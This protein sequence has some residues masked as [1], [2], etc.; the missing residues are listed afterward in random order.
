MRV[1]YPALLTIALGSQSNLKIEAVGNALNQLSINA[2][3]VACKVASSVAEQPFEQ[4]TIE[5]AKNRAREAATLLRDADLA[6]AIENGI[7]LRDGYWQDIGIVVAWSKYAGGD[8]DD[9]FTL[10]ESAP[11]VFPASIVEEVK[12]LGVDEWT[13][14]K[15]MARRQIVSKH[16]DPHMSLTGI[17]RR[18]YLENAIVTLMLELR[19]R[20]LV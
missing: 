1:N 13:C 11:V 20:S 18:I 16:D 4:E 9:K 5:G 3:L 6:I 2:N 12:R 14:G 10:V 8:G 17:S 19:A 7:F 15:L